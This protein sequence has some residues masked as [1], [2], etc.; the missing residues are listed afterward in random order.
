MKLLLVLLSTILYFKLEA[1]TFK[2]INN[3]DWKRKSTWSKGIVPPSTIS[4]N[5]TIII[6]HSISTKAPL[7]NAGTIYIEG[8]LVVKKNIENIGFITISKNG[9]LSVHKI[10]FP[11]CGYGVLT[12]NGLVEAA[13]IKL[14]P[15]GNTCGPGTNPK[16]DNYAVI[17]VKGEI[18][19][20]NSERCGSLLNNVPGVI[21]T[22]KLQN[23]GYICNSS[24][25]FCTSKFLLVGGTIECCGNVVTPVFKIDKNGSNLGNSVCQNYCTK[26]LLEGGK[27]PVIK[28][29][30]TQQQATAEGGFANSRGIINVPG[31]TFCSTTARP[32]HPIY[33]EAISKN[34][35]STELVWQ[36]QHRAN[37]SYFILEK[38]SNT[39]SWTNL[40]K[41]EAKVNTEEVTTYTFIDENATDK[42]TYYRLK[43]V[44]KDGKFSYSEIKVDKYLDPE[45]SFVIFPNPA[46]NSFNLLSKSTEIIVG[47]VTVYSV[48]GKVMFVNEVQMNINTPLKM[49]ITALKEG[50][51]VLE[52]SSKEYNFKQLFTK[53]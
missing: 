3:G 27:V 6:K 29:G 30:L 20:G 8:K 34:E 7:T 4:G 2:T 40:T 5:D 47:T 44:A 53:Y 46:H 33:F 15:S 48:E 23:N 37:Y 26:D 41:V 42:Q 13:K 18:E 25:I 17:Q 10:V 14:T 21:T 52:F 28:G 36:T 38:S 31:T 16:I 50:M 32:L 39:K 51:Y 49:D 9:A 19:V 45:K 43:K 1:N 22:K 11:R 12:N 24:S 35:T